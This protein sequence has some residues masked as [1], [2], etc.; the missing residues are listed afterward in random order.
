MSKFCKNCGAKVNPGAKFC[1]G[2]GAVLGAVTQIQP[3]QRNLQPV[4]N[5]AKS[6]VISSLQNAAAQAAELLA[7][8]TVAA[9]RQAG[10]WYSS[11]RFRLWLES[12]SVPSSFA[13]R[14][15]KNFQGL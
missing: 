7:G 6:P 5:E 10:I 1:K 8:R 15:R 11:G 3:V 9:A 2:C 13:R 12:N 4:E 14:Y